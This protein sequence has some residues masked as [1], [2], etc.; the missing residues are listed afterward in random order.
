MNAKPSINLTFLLLLFFF[1]FQAA[2]HAQNRAQA[3]PRL[4]PDPKA[5]EFFDIKQKENGYSWEELAEISLWASGDVSASNLGRIRAAAE[6]LNN[7]PELPASGRERAEF[8]LSFMHKNIFRSYSLYQTRIDTIFTNGR[9]NCVS[10]AV[11]YTILCKSA[12]IN[13]S[14]VITKEHAFAIVHIG[15]SN[16]DVETTNPY[17]FDPGNRKDFFDSV[18][19][20]TGFS[21]VPA[22]NYRDRQTI[23]QI[24]LVSLILN[25]RIADHERQNRYGDAV[26]VAVDMAALLTGNTLAV[27]DER[28]GP[29]FK[30]PVSSMMD[31]I[32][33]YG[34]MLLRAGRE[35]DCLRWAAAASQL[36]PD[37][38][39]WQ[40][41]TLVAIN[42]N[43]TKL[44]RA[45]KITDAR[46]FLDNNKIF[47][48][49]AGYAQYDTALLDTEL[50]NS[51]GRIR[52]AE[53][54]DSVVSAV[55]KALQSGRIEQKRASE[56]ITFAIQ[57]TAAALSA[58][59]SRDW[60][61]A[62]N[63]I[64]T[65]LSRF[66][67]NMEP[68]VNEMF[69]YELEQAIQ[70]YRGNIAADYHNR[71]AAAWNRRNFEEAERILNEGLAEFPADRQLLS[72]LETIRRQHAR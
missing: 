71:F 17:G 25:N 54:G 31:R 4:E 27:K 42:N 19:N 7:S 52:T 53:E 70:T 50:R 15:D 22:Q 2:V 11:L 47:L 61:A 36:Y 48:T 59:P 26:P 44:L 72:N 13:T 66:G 29:L 3:F 68:P 51:A 55:E 8:I 58:A 35:E 46:N 41:F 20:I 64:E 63:Y 12:G 1:N 23:S 37:A 16:I 33:N 9:Y 10:S 40:E 18:G 30:N 38:A 60:R 14:G 49:N 69:V 21:Y 6:R 62:V 57:K 45:S 5:L 56:L 28:P 24:E 43:I 65:A 67:A 39:R 32:F 34:A